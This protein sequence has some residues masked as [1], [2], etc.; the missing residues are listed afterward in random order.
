MI[1]LKQMELGRLAG[2]WSRQSAALLTDML[3][4]WLCF[5]LVLCVV[6]LKLLYGI[7]ELYPRTDYISSNYLET[8]IVPSLFAVYLSS[9]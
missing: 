4:T 9:Y 7:V 1:L 5:V 8:N 2:R 3:S 6:W